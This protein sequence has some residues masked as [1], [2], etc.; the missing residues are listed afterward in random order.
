MVDCPL[1][2]QPRLAQRGNGALFLADGLLMKL[3]KQLN[4]S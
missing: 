2:L 4:I 1:S 3:F